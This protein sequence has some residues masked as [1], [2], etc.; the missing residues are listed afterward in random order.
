MYSTE[1]VKIIMLSLLTG[2][3]TNLKIKIVIRVIISTVMD[4]V[5]TRKIIY[6]ALWIRY[7]WLK[8]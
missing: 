8:N 5:G 1:Y 3:K 2:E 7:D 6:K 4:C